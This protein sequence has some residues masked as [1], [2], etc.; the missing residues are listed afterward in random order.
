M[1]YFRKLIGEKC[2]LSPLSIEDAERYTEWLNDMEIGQ[3]ILAAS[4]N[5]DVDKERDILKRLMQNNIIFSIVDKDTN[6]AIGI[7]GLHDVSDVHRR[8]T[9]G[10]FIGD[11][12]YWNQGIGTEATALL[13]DYGFNILNLNNITLEVVEYNRR[14]IKCYEKIGFKYIG[15]HRSYMFM[16][17][18][19]HDVLIYDILASEFASTYVN[20]VFERSTSEDAGRSKITI[21]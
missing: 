2:Y 8:A 7:C 11:K 3:F 12:A 13:T 16:A 17:G 18:K 4:Q 9:L 14:A 1:K 5:I 20:K 19:Y 21:E 15:K 6:K 10:I